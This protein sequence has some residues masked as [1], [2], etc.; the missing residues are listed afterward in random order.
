MKI[1]DT[2][3]I[4]RTL[5]KLHPIELRYRL[6]KIAEMKLKRGLQVWPSGGKV[7]K[8]RVKNVKYGYSFNVPCEVMVTQYELE[9][10]DEEAFINGTLK[11]L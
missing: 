4:T 3:P 1:D 7:T 9:R 5:E 2:T 11:T 6:E 10:F 8:S